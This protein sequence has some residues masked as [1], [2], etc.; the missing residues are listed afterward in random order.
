M[1]I[2]GGA[3]G[4]G[5]AIAR[6]FGQEGARV[7][8]LDRDRDALGR[9]AND[10]TEGV[11]PLLADVAE[12]DSLR[13]AFTRMDAVWGGLDVVCNNAGISIRRAFLETSLAEWEQTLRVNLTGAFLVAREAGRRMKSDG[14]VIIN[15]ASVSGMVGMPDYAA[16]N[17]SKAG[18]IELTRTL[19]LELAPRV[20]VNAICP[21]YVLTPMQRAEY[22]EEQLAEQ[23]GTLPLG[24]LG[25]PEEIAALVAYLASPD[26]AFI[27]G[28]TLVIDGGETA[29]GLASAARRPDGPGE[30]R[31]T[32]SDPRR[33]G[34]A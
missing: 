29:G 30:R 12:E 17:V 13:E 26:A 6:R 18:L 5:A 3:S 7:A 32:T 10:A 4:I 21:G 1:L 15:T 31:P 11:L 27:T 2:T 19:A 8:V 24:R 22:T 34:G 20:R 25:T 16:Y 33:G 23:A 28:Q 9:F 14:G